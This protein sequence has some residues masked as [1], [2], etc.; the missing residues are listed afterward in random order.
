MSKRLYS[1]DPHESTCEDIRDTLSAIKIDLNNLDGE[2]L[3]VSEYSD[4]KT[5]IEL[6]IVELEACL[7]SLDFHK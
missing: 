3:T 4:L 2:T 1:F 7:D 5:S 6:K